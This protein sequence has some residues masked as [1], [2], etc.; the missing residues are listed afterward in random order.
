MNGG[1][2]GAGVGSYLNGVGIE[3]IV[4]NFAAGAITGAVA[5]GISSAIYGGN[6]GQ[7][8]LSGAAGGAIG[9]GVGMAT[10]A[11]GT[12]VKGMSATKQLACANGLGFMTATD[13][14]QAYPEY[15]AMID[16]ILSSRYDAI[17][18]ADY[19]IALAT[20]EDIGYIGEKEWD[21]FLDSARCIADES[22][23]L[24]PLA[25]MSNGDT[26]YDNDQKLYS[27]PSI[28]KISRGY[29]INYI[30]QG[31]IYNRSWVYNKITCYE[32]PQLWKLSQMPFSNKWWKIPME[33]YKNREPYQPL[34]RDEKFYTHYGF[35]HYN[36]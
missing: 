27:I 31:M 21:A 26:L 4:G 11:I 16:S 23:K 8:M 18:I 12:W 13:S 15:Q 7:N 34:S 29:E 14:P 32:L 1:S 10:K 33:Y 9:A 3:C 35:K 24:N 19:E 22:S 17:D 25:P 20:G 30:L 2:F 36:N 28:G 5:G 6:W